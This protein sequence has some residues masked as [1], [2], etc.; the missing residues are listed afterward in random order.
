MALQL[1][2]TQREAIQPNRH[3][4]VSASAGSGKT[5][6]L[7]SRYLNLLLQDIRPHHLLCLTYTRSG[8]SEM[9]QRIT[10]DLARWSWL[11]E[12]QLSE[13][14]QR[15]IGDH[16]VNE[17]LIMRARRLFS[18]ILDCPDGIRIQTIHA[19]C[20][21]ILTRFPI[22]AGIHPGYEL[23]EP[24]M[25]EEMAAQAMNRFLE[26]S[27]RE[28]EVRAALSVLADEYAATDLQS[29]FLQL[30]LGYAGFGAHDDVGAHDA[31]LGKVD[32]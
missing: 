24:S 30:T 4:W 3:I 20:Q 6:I 25:L 10:H 16:K 9:A 31:V 28:P 18:E 19:F 15:L 11:P 22:E 26:Q 2:E 21:S 5:E 32:S 13:A 27:G 8:A 14:L 17:A 12:E 29:I 7:K 1:L 23:L